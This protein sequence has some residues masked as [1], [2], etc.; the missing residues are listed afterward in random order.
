MYVAEMA[1]LLDT[2]SSVK[3]DGFRS[4]LEVSCMSSLTEEELWYNETVFVDD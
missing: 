2:M 4:Q 3:L 1:K